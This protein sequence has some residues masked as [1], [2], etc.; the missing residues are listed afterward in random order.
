DRLQERCITFTVNEA[1]FLG[2][3][4][5]YFAPAL[6]HKRRGGKARSAGHSEPMAKL[7]NAV[8]AFFVRN[9]KGRDGFHPALRYS[10]LTEARSAA[11]LMPRAG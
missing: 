2:P 5:T 8:S 10:P 9:P 6:L 11:R 3:V 4:N 7:C 1:F